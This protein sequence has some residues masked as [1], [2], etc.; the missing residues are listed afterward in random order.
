MHTA[1]KSGRSFSRKKS[2]LGDEHRIRKYRGI[3]HP[4]LRLHLKPNNHQIHDRRCA[5]ERK[6]KW[7]RTGDVQRHHHGLGPWEK[8]EHWCSVR[9]PQE[10]GTK[11]K[12]HQDHYHLSHDERWKIL[13][14]L[15]K[16]THL[17]N[18]RQD[19]P[20]P[21]IL[22]KGS[23]K[24][25]RWRSCKKSSGHPSA[26]T[27]GRHPNLYDRS[28]GH[29]MHMQTN[30]IKIRHSLKRSEVT[31]PSNILPTAFLRTG[32]DLWEFLAAKVHSG[33]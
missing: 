10:S 28:G 11:T 25:L 15:R 30:P 31:H 26:A 29:R 32:K 18:P 3:F 1:S 24:R 6:S 27:P 33:N 16:R 19:I 20:S 22:R 13:S 7:W 8:L 17:L 2:V 5:A 14:L 4:F 23:R 12:R 9:Y 21:K